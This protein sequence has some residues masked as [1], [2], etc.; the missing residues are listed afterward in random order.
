M[1]PS[2][3]LAMSSCRPTRVNTLVKVQCQQQLEQLPLVAVAGNGSHLPTDNGDC[4]ASLP[5]AC[6]YLDEIF[7]SGRSQQE[8]LRNLEVLKRLEEAGLRLKREKHLPDAR[9]RVLGAQGLP[10]GATANRDQGE[11]RVLQKPHSPSKWLSKD[12]SLGWLT[13]TAKYC[14]T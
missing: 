5:Q 12:P 4:A 1:T 2:S 11:T 6:V 13:I 14:A 3:I 7:V 8:H 10:G 9:S